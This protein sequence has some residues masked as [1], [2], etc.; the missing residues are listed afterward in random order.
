MSTKLFVKNMVCP[1]CIK[2]VG[3][4][5]HKLGLTVKEIELGEVLVEEDGSQIPY[6]KV[7]EAL[8]KEGFELLEDSKGRIIEAIKT[9]IISLI[10]KYKDENLEQI[11]FSQYLSKKL[12][13]DYSQLSTLFSRMEGITI[14]H[15]VIK[16]KIEK[17]KELLK[18]GEMTLSE[19]A[20]F[21]GYSSVAHLSRQFKQITGMTASEFKNNLK[22][23]RNSIDKV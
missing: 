7:K 12:N 9:E 14:E 3:E 2:V 4:E 6:D 5:L 16:Q 17:A 20:Y 1:R 15:F 13:R 8:Q 18:Y 23:L 11:V 21:L 10:Q 22:N 19:I